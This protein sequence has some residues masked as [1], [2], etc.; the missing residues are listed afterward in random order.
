MFRRAA[1]AQAATMAH[2]MGLFKPADGVTDASTQI[3]RDFTAWVLSSHTPSPLQHEPAASLPDPEANLACSHPSKSFF[4]STWE[5]SSCYDE[6]YKTA[7]C[8][9]PILSLWYQNILSGICQLLIPEIAAAP[10][11]DLRHVV[12][13]QLLHSKISFETLTELYYLRNGF[14][15]GNMMLLYCLA[16]LSFATLAERQSAKTV[17]DLESMED[18]RSTFILAAKGL[19]DQGKNY[20]MSAIISRILQSQL[21]PEDV[22]ILSQYCCLRN[23][24]TTVQEA[25][26]AHVRAQYPLSIVN[27]TDVPEGQGLENMIKKYEELALKQVS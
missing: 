24:P 1:G 22:D 21:P 20:F 7:L 18:T 19:H 27:M 5:Y 2:K 17:T 13:A 9:G 10:V 25:R 11:L 26:A 23:E 12:E 6:Q 16:V 4:R 15:S 8:Y 14:D 3:V